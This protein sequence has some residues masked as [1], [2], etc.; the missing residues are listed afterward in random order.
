VC[1]VEALVRWNHPKRG[2][3]PPDGFIPL[4]E[5]TGLI[6]ALTR[7]VIDASLAQCRAWQEVGRY[8]KVAVNI[9]ARNLIDDHF[10]DTVQQLLAKWQ[11]APSCLELEV[12]ES[13]IMADPYRAQ[14]TLTALSGLGVKLAIDDFGAGYTSLAH[15]KNLPVDVLKIDQSFVG[16]MMEDGKDAAIVRLLI[17]LAHDLGILSVAEGVEDRQTLERLAVLG[18]D[19]AQGYYLSRPV[20]AE[21]LEEWF[22]DA[23]CRSTENVSVR[24]RSSVR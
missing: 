22:D 15:L 1:G 2:L 7:F 8:H 14:A 17:E 6:R 19:V 23:S 20:P 13:A 18:C 21:Q 11:L 5:Q 16:Q 4:A 12:T 10:V 24:T 9:S 3:I